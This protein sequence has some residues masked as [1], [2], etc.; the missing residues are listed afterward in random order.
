MVAGVPSHR[1][2]ISISDG[3]YL[4]GISWGGKGSNYIA[5]VSWSPS[6]TP[7]F[8]NINGKQIRLHLELFEE[9]DCVSNPL[10]RVYQIGFSYYY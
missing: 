4:G 8:L 1:V 3:K 10:W 5:E 9:N 2:W 6:T 7:S